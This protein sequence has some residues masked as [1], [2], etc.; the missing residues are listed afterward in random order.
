M[1]LW[2]GGDCR[3]DGERNGQKEGGTE[4]LHRGRVGTV[5]C[6]EGDWGSRGVRGVED[7]Q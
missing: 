6:E 5:G 3:R 7:G 4:A 2:R 1:G